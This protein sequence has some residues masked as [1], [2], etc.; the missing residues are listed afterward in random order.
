MTDTI[1]PRKTVLI[2]EDDK[3]MILGLEENLKFEGYDVLTAADGET[4]L[5]LALEKRPDLILLD[6]VLPGMTGYQVCKTLRDEGRHTPVVMLTARGEEVDKI[7]GF[8]MGADDYMTKPFSVR[9]LLARIKAVL[10][11]AERRGDTGIKYLFGDFILDLRSRTLM[12]KGKPDKEITL[13]RTELELLACLISNAGKAM[14]REA[15][16]D[17][18]WGT[19]YLGTQRSLDTFIAGLRSKIEANPGNP[20]F[21]LTVHGVGYKFVRA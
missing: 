7:T 18:V 19:Q 16:L 17:E 3:A 2:V 8:D 11:R 21:I 12:K 5:R 6:I 20:H 1:Q 13:T 10:R 14:S 9:E 15:L 4:G